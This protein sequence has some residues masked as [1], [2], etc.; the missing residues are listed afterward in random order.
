[1]EPVK[2]RSVPSLAVVTATAMLL[3]GLRSLSLPNTIE[4][5]VMAP[6]KLG[7]VVR[8]MVAIPP[9]CILPKVQMITPPW[10]VQFPCV[11]SAETIFKLGGKR[12][13]T[14]TVL[15]VAGPWFRT[16]MV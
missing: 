10:F 16:V 14:L 1:M 4:V 12:F 6:G 13:V 8:V 3:D 5:L 9:A 11:E 7:A 15:A 2:V